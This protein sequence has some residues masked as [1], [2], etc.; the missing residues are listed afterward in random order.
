MRHGAASLVESVRHAHEPGDA[1]DAP[2]DAVEAE[3]PADEPEVLTRGQ[4][5]VQQRVVSHDTYFAADA[6]AVLIKGDATYMNTPGVGFRQSG[7][8]VDESRLAGAVWSEK[9]EHLSGRHVQVYPSKDRRS[10]EG[11]G[12]TSE[13]DGVVTV[14]I[15]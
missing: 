3:H 8:N 14:V 13:T 4:V 11:L 1:L 15:S 6:R 10:S 5:V 12:N 2:I 7:E 9:A